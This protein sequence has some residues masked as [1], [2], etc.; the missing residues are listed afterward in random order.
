MIVYMILKIFSMTSRRTL[1][2]NPILPRPPPI[3]RG[4]DERDQLAEA[5]HEV[6]AGADH[7]VDIGAEADTGGAEVE[8]NP[9]REDIEVTVERE[10]ATG[11]ER[12]VLRDTAGLITM[13][14]TMIITLD[15]GELRTGELADTDDCNCVKNFQIM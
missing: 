3:P 5:G 9:T 10:V 4:A 2:R 13:T 6:V 11:A 1:K 8:V 15:I 12:E 14:T 7:G